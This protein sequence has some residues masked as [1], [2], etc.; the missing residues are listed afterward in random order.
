MKAKLLFLLFLF[1]FFQTRLYAQDEALSFDNRS[2]PLLSSSDY[3]LLNHHLV[4]SYSANSS[5]RSIVIIQQI[6]D[7]NSFQLNVNTP[8]LNLAVKQVGNYNELNLS[9]TAPIFSPSYEQLGD[10]NSINTIS[11]YSTDKI[12]T[13]FIQKGNNLN[14]IN[15]GSNSIS[16]DMIISQ[17]GNSGLVYIF[18][19]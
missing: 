15:L 17:H 16:K 8:N 10:S 1:Q 19:H 5:I 18:N 6:G 3:L 14:L 2:Y 11:M 13:Q 12:E 7:K 9:A 4:N